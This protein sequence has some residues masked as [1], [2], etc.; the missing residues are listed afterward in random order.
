MPVGVCGHFV[1]DDSRNLCCKERF[2]YRE[3]SVAIKGE[4]TVKE[5]GEVVVVL[6]ELE[7]E[8]GGVFKLI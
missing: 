2:F 5:C 1:W 8:G 7:A 6:G 3:F 4:E